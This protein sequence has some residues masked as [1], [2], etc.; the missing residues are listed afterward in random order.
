MQVLKSLSQGTNFLVLA[1]KTG[2]PE[3]RNELIYGSRLVAGYV[4][5]KAKNLY[6]PLL[7]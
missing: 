7:F 6:D 5:E 3:V 2:Y 4:A 1:G